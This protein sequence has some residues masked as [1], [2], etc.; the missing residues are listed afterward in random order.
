MSGHIFGSHQVCHLT[1][2]NIS[3]VIVFA[4]L[5]LDHNRNKT[6][7][8]LSSRQEK[9]NLNVDLVMFVT[10]SRN[11]Y[12]LRHYVGSRFSPTYVIL[13]HSTFLRND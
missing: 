4:V 3:I 11:S 1:A 5:S 8:Y 6:M 2:E 13:P 7:H 9:I 10:T 12:T